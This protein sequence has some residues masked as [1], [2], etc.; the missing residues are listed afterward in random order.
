MKEGYRL[1]ARSWKLVQED[2]T[3]WKKE[4]LLKLGRGGWH[5]WGFGEAVEEWHDALYVLRQS[6]GR[7][8]NSQYTYFS[9]QCWKHWYCFVGLRILSLWVC[10][11]SG[12]AKTAFLISTPKLLCRLVCE[13]RSLACDPDS[14]RWI[15]NQESDGGWVVEWAWKPRIPLL[16]PEQ[17]SA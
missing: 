14:W 10:L 5:H 16:C 3:T 4:S 8:I 11:G 7:K 2:W 6:L 12:R 9:I 13:A 17:S 1:M 15:L